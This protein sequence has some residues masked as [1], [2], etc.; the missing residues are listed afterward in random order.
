[1]REI[2]A[3]TNFLKKYDSRFDLLTRWSTFEKI[4]R[5]HTIYLWMT[6]NISYASI[7]LEKI[8]KFSKHG[9]ERAHRLRKPILWRSWAVLKQLQNEQA[10]SLVCKK[11]LSRRPEAIEHPEMILKNER[12]SKISHIIV[13]G[14][15]ESSVE[16][17]E[18]VS[19]YW[20]IYKGICRSI[21]PVGPLQHIRFENLSSFLNISHPFSGQAN[22]VW[23]NRPSR[24]MFRWIHGVTPSIFRPFSGHL[25]VHFEN[26]SFEAAWLEDTGSPKYDFSQHIHRKGRWQLTLFVILILNPDKIMV[27]PERNRPLIWVIFAY[28]EN[29]TFWKYPL[30]R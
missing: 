1:M 18:S 24:H 9:S 11:R 17:T 19:P 2:G 6:K 29:F 21:N 3:I 25:S 23:I 4:F 7:F 5:P 22:C 10:E 12:F 16:E 28:S 26:L 8:A 14:F 20:C 13:L 15:W 30:S 27:F